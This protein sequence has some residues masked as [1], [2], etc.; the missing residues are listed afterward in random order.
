MIIIT[1]TDLNSRL[2]T[3]IVYELLSTFRRLADCLLTLD[4]LLTAIRSLAN[5][6]LLTLDI[7][8][9]AVRSLAN[10]CLLMLDILLTAIRS[11]ANDCLLI[12]S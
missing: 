5:D 3:C 10:D 11:I 7:L 4:I 9:T 2:R 1:E 12:A 6:C 8:L